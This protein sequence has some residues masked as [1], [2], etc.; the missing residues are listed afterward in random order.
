MKI[1]D[2][3]KNH[4][5]TIAI[6]L[7]IIVTAIL[8]FADR[9]P[10][11][12]VLSYLLCAVG[13]LAI[14]VFFASLESEKSIR[15]VMER[16]KPQSL[17]KKVTR[18]EH[19]QLLNTAAINANSQIWLMTIDSAL[20]RKVVSTIPEREIYY[21]TIETIAKTKREVSVRR[22]YGLPVDDSARKDKIKWIRSDIEKI[23]DCSNYHIRIFDWRK[24]DSIPSPLSLQIVDDTFVGLV[25][26][27]QATTGVE[28]GGEDICIE[29]RNV[30][31]HLRLYYETVWEKCDELKTGNNIMYDHLR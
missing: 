5:T 14:D 18:K 8:S 3:L 10:D 4:Y 22:I 2:I 30:V 20:S 16:L 15:D 23:K 9:I 1:K 17:S 7:A 27:Q 21:R 19:Y 26:L 11:E 31:Q 12:D 25:N 24:F 28:G 6:I 13:G 29:D